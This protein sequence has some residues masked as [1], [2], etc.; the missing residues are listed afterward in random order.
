MKQ[1]SDTIFELVEG[2]HYLVDVENI[3]FILQ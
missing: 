1:Y 2:S 3:L